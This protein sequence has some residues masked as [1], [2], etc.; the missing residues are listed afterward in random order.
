MCWPPQHVARTCYVFWSE[1]PTIFSFSMWSNEHVIKN[2]TCRVFF[3]VRIWADTYEGT[4]LVDLKIWSISL[5][6]EESMEFVKHFSHYHYLAVSITSQTTG[7]V[8]DLQLPLS[9]GLLGLV[10]SQKQRGDVWEGGGAP[11]QTRPPSV[12]IKDSL[13]IQSALCKWLLNLQAHRHGQADI[14]TSCF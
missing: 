13:Y 11:L 7:T 8:T 12:N 3:I 1:R 6:R 14:V 10:G 2:T 9:P 4:L 5:Q